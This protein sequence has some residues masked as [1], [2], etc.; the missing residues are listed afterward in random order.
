ME[1]MNGIVSCAE[2]FLVKDAELRFTSQGKAVC[3][4]SLAVAD[5]KRAEDGETE[6]LRVTLW[7]AEAER[8]APVLLKGVE[9]YVYG[10][11]KLRSW[12]SDAG[13]TRSG[14]ELSAWE[15]TPKGAI[16]HRAPKQQGGPSARDVDAALNL[17]PPRR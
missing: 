15:C 6:W 1:G 5:T 11:L 14:L 8:L 12:Q 4:F 10:R 16:G 9:C 13:E 17:I 2:G 3:S 7:E